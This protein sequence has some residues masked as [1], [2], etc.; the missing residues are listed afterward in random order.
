MVGLPQF[1]KYLQMSNPNY[2]ILEETQDSVSMLIVDAY[3]TCCMNYMGILD[4]LYGWYE[5]G[6]Y[7]LYKLDDIV[8]ELNRIYE[9][10]KPYLRAHLRPYADKIY[11]HMYY[12]EVLTRH[13]N[14]NATVKITVYDE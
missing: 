7:D 1:K 3:L 12:I 13:S 10:M 9:T 11:D 5:N 14:S 2:C 4:Y 6:D 8:Q